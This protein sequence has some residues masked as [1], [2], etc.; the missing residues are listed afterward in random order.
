MKAASTDFLDDQKLYAPDSGSDSDPKVQYH[1]NIGRNLYVIESAGM[2]VLN[3]VDMPQEVVGVPA[4]GTY[5]DGPVYYLPYRDDIIVLYQMDMPDETAQQKMTD[6][7][8]YLA[9][10]S[11]GS[12]SPKWSISGI[13]PGGAPGVTSG[14]L[15]FVG[16]R[17]FLGAINLDTGKYWWCLRDLDKNSQSPFKSVKTPV[18]RNDEV[19]LEDA[20]TDAYGEHYYVA[21]NLKTQAIN[22]NVPYSKPL[23][24]TDD[25]PYFR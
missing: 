2:A 21:V 6:A 8:V 20:K 17:G 23:S 24:V 22:T 12:R 9:R 5:I 4:N 13:P 10:A 16:S 1:F 14:Q 15:I 11:I 3:R 18:M 19:V 7:Y 25:C